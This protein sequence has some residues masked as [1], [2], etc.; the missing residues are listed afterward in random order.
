VMGDV[1]VAYIEGAAAGT[2]AKP[3]R[4]KTAP[5]IGALRKRG[6]NLAELITRAN[7][8]NGSETLIGLR[9]A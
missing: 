7:I 5:S 2:V 3:V 8:T 9:T 6:A 4:R 1:L